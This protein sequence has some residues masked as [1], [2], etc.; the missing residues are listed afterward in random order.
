MG[1][2]LIG[3]RIR[4]RRRALGITQ[5][6]LAAR[7]EISP[8]YL[9]LIEGN[10]R[11]IGGAL[12]RRIA[13]ELGLAVDEVLAALGVP[14]AALQLDEGGL[15]PAV[16]VE[17]DFDQVG[18][19]LDV[20]HR[21]SCVRS[22]GLKAYPC[23]ARQKPWCPLCRDRVVRDMAPFRPGTQSA[24]AAS[25]AA[26]LPPL[27]ALRPKGSRSVRGQALIELTTSPVADSG[28]RLAMSEIVMMPTSRRFSITGSR[29]I[30][31]S[32]I[33]AMVMSTSSFASARIR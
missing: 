9:N 25:A 21:S 6:S 5:A 18:V 2:S 32:F 31:C 10:K 26:A 13:D 8:S 3:P 15:E 19:R 24:A 12:L 33:L 1:R 29:L 23:A 28:M 17:D 20:R 4:D 11:N 22:F 14:G 16:V 30:W 27:V 7:V